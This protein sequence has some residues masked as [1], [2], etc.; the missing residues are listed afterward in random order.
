[1]PELPEVEILIRHL[2]PLIKGRTIR[3]V[4]VRRAKVIAPTSERE[5]KQTLSGAKFIDV[6]RRGKYLLFTLRKAD[7]RTPL[8]LLGHLGMTGRMYLLSKKAPLP[9]H[10]A[11]TMDLGQV[12][13][14][15]ED[16]R[17]FGRLTL[18]TSSIAALGPE[19]LGPEF[20]AAYFA[21]ALK[22]SSQPIKIKLL[23]QSLVA[24]VGN[25][26]A[27]E[28]LYRAGISPRLAANKLKPPQIKLLRQAIRD[29]L[30][31]AIKCGSTLPLD[32]EGSGSRD[33]LFYYGN[34]GNASE[35]YQERLL[36]Y[37]RHGKP[38]ARCSTGIKR[39]VQ[40][41]RSTFYCPRCQR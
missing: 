27:S 41:A 15:Y 14:I 24:G 9:K 11:V 7:Q 2:S 29:V 3:N 25:I 39:F 31:K 26:Y 12:Q 5:L 18:D 6:T 17:Y 19:P 35:F 21:T 38:C 34:A 36:V 13:F 1:M 33:G 40:A 20:T 23:D 16:T 22:R 32:F 8:S 4:E 10:A 37:D 28:A 30:N